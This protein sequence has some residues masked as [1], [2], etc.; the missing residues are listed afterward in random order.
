MGGKADDGIS[1]GVAANV[2]HKDDKG[3]KELL[4]RKPRYGIKHSF[5]KSLATL[6]LWE[7]A[8]DVHGL[9]LHSHSQKDPWQAVATIRRCCQYKQDSP[10]LQV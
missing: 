8:L 3:P 10:H 2:E 5:G 7:H 1:W 4:I 6:L 9:A